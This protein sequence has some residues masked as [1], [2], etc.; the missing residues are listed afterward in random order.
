MAARKLTEDEIGSLA[1]IFGEEADWRKS[2]PS[3]HWQLG[4][5]GWWSHDRAYCVFGGCPN[6]PGDIPHGGGND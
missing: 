2:L 5:S 3:R 6:S 1:R 4:P